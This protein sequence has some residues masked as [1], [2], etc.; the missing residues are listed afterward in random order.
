MQTKTCYVC[1]AEKNVEL[2]AQANNSKSADKRATY[3][4]DCSATLTEKE[5]GAIVTALWRK[6]NKERHD[7]THKNHSLNKAYG[8][9]LEEYNVMLQAQNSVCAVCGEAS[10]VARKKDGPLH[11]LCVDH[12]TGVI[13]GLLCGRCNVLLELLEQNPRRLTQLRA[14]LRKHAGKGKKPSRGSGL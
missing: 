9:S 4:L 8:I 1:K 14:Y 7:K 3:C 5:K 2:F 11:S 13:R 6:H 12:E 10:T